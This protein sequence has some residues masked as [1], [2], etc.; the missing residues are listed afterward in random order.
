M[1]K[2][3]SIPEIIRHLNHEFLNK[4]NLIQMYIDLGKIEES[5]KIIRDMAEHCKVVSNIHQL[6]CPKLITWIETFTFNFPAIRFKIK[7]NV[8]QPIPIQLDEKIEEYLNRSV[9][10][11][12][13]EIDPYME[14][15]LT[16][17]ID[18]DKDQFAIHF[19]LNGNWNAPKFNTKNIEDF[20]VETFEETNQTW[21]FV[22]RS[23]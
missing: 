22:I 12:Y 14:H 9:C 20:I 3:L 17:T 11:V 4:V 18:S 21:K 6:K 2:E 16:L 8:K 23:K 7:S 19:D 13:E 10:H 15:N 1:K 5:K